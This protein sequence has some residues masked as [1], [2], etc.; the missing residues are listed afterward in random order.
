[1]DDDRGG[2]DGVDGVD[3]E[4][5]KVQ[6]FSSSGGDG[7]DLVDAAAGYRRYELWKMLEECWLSS[8]LYR[9][10]RVVGNP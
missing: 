3:D 8:T 7:G 6:V 10:R 9:P 1:M 2:D 4:A 5:F